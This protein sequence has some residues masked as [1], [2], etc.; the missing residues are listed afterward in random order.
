MKAER[1]EFFDGL[2]LVHVYKEGTRSVAIGIMT[3]VGSANE[4]QKNNGVS[5]FI[6]HMFFKGTKTRSSV[7]ILKEVDGVGAQINAFTSKS[8]TCFYTFSV[9]D[10]CDKCAEILSDIMFNSTFDPEELERE[11]KVVLEEISM[12]ED[13]NADLCSELMTM[14]FY[15]G[16]SLGLPILGTRKTV[17]SLK[18]EDL[19]GYISHNYS[20]RDTVISI[21]GNIT[22]EKAVDLVKKYFEGRFA[23]IKG[24]DWK[25]K[26]CEPVS[27]SVTKIK[28]I[29]QANVSIAFPSVSYCSDDYYLT[30]IGG[31]VFGNGM[32]S[33]LFC[34][35]RE[36]YGLA[37]NV[38]SY[39][40]GY[41]NNGYSCVYV[42]TNPKSVAKSV[43]IVSEIIDD[44]TKNGFTREE[45][46]RGLQQA[47]ANYIL[48]QEGVGSLMRLY[49]KKLLF[50]DEIFDFDDAIKKIEKCSFSMLNEKFAT[51]FDK[52]RAVVSYVG[53]K[54]GEDLLAILQGR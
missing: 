8:V 19:I 32:S 9:D 10:R 22:K 27:A 41:I 36:K 51:E 42:G 24:R 3:G 16:N 53:K 50:Q 46:E 20:A 43:E 34:E 40:T 18:R 15:E 48:G 28:N 35:V 44:V 6:E 1:I 25:D 31:F 30:Q 21:V 47:R 5:H 26:A 39:N 29:E 54:T 45:Y 38:Y 49:A 7:D 13:D 4:T 23:D 52:S 17:K 12:S 14:K 11:R 37:Y 33:R 2:R